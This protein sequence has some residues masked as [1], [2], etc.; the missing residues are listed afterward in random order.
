MTFSTN[1]L[2]NF[3]MVEP[4]IPLPISI[5]L[6]MLRIELKKISMSYYYP[7]NLLIFSTIRTWREK[8]KNPY[9]RLKINLKNYLANEI[10]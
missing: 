5:A 9:L 6:K 8:V 10:Y 7:Q 1:S 2:K 4:L 3:V